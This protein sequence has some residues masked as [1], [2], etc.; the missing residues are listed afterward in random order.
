MKKFFFFAA[1]AI[2]AAAC[3][4]EAPQTSG[5]TQVEV[6]APAEDGAPMAIAFGTN[7]KATVATKAQ[8]SVDTWNANQKLYV[9]GFEVLPNKDAEGNNIGGSYLDYT[10][11]PYIDNVSAMS[12]AQALDDEDKAVIT[13]SGALDV[14]N[15]KDGSYYYYEGNKTYDFFGYYIDDLPSAPVPT[16][17]GIYV[18]V[19]L[20]G[21][22]D[23]MVAKAD[24]TEDYENA[25]DKDLFK[26]DKN[27]W[28]VNYAYSAYA[29]RRGIQPTLKFEHQLVQFTFNIESGSDDAVAQGLKVEG[30]SLTA[31]YQANLYVAGATLGFQD[32]NAEKKAL[33]L[34]GFEPY[35]VPNSETE[36]QNEEGEIVKEKTKP[37]KIGDCIMAIPNTTIPAEGDKFE[38][39]LY[40]SQKGVTVTE[41][42]ENNNLLPGMPVNFTLKFSE[43]KDVP[44]NEEGLPVISAFEAGY[45]F[46][47]TIKVY[48]L[49][50][51][52]ISAE[53]TEWVNGGNVNIDT[54]EAP[55]IF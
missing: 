41:T 27:S 10:A 46:D 20:T 26:G 1:A 2:V 22:E 53:L 49:E 39:T 55:E 29:A 40:L 54:D 37:V 52:E 44:V 7:L 45:S 16:K 51:I 47:V 30:L 9:Y 15:P 34:F 43:V 48:S 5:Q 4:K 31:L 24:K 18:P 42:D 32:I 19:T 11:D 17:N 50:E 21:G 38:G 12:P 23:I 13:L 25:V 28:N 6:A 14:K 3:A 35:A 36:T 8:G 33:K